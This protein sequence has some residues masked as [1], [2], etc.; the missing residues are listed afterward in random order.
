MARW[1]KSRYHLARRYSRK[2]GLHMEMF[3]PSLLLNVNSFATESVS[4]FLR[5]HFRPDPDWFKDKSTQILNE[6]DQWGET[7]KSGLPRLRHERFAYI[8]HNTDGFYYGNYVDIACQRF[9]WPEFFR[10]FP[11]GKILILEIDEEWLHRII[12]GQVDQAFKV[13]WHEKDHIYNSPQDMSGLKSDFFPISSLH[14]A[15]FGIFPLTLFHLHYPS[16]HLLFVYVPPRPLQHSKMMESS[17]FNDVLW[18]LSHVYSAHDPK[19]RYGGVDVQTGA[20]VEYIAWFVRMVGQRMEDIL[21]IED[22]LKREQLAMTFNR[23]VCDGTLAVASELPYMAK[24]FFFGCLDKLANIMAQ[25]GR[26]DNDAAAW[27]YLMSEEFWAGDLLNFVSGI[28][29]FPK[30]IFTSIIEYVCMSLRH[31]EVTM[32]L[33]RDVRNSI[34]GYSLRP[35]SVERLFRHSGNFDNDIP[36]LATPILLYILSMPWSIS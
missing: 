35:D 14:I 5:P 4:D 12:A 31:D 22:A 19:G 21:R 17:S 36:L 32:Q 24:T 26:F 29:E 10:L 2:T 23:A 18:S 28:S 27:R 20:S 11:K 3:R 15:Q 30:T 9:V 6:L 25:I 1:L 34:H 7:F 16:L 8:C 33:L 13:G